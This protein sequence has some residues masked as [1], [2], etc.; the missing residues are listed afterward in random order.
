MTKPKQYST[1]T[2]IK[3]NVQTHAYHEKNSSDSHVAT[4]LK[5]LTMPLNMLSHKLDTVQLLQL[6]VLYLQYTAALAIQHSDIINLNMKSTHLCNLT[7]KASG[8]S[9]QLQSEEQCCNYSTY[10]KHNKLKT[11]SNIVRC[12]A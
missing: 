8:L 3:A 5:N 1:I 10:F 9:K 6:S 11:A 12:L 2:Q 4:R 7:Y